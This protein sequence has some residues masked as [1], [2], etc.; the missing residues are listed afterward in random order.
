MGEKDV[1]KTPKGNEIPV[2]EREEFMANL[3]RASKADDPKPNDSE[4]DDTEKE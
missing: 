2:P 1:Q 4:A 3:R